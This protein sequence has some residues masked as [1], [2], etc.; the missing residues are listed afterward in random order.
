M[1]F[2]KLPEKS[3]V[4][5]LQTQLQTVLPDCCINP[6][7]IFGSETKDALSKFQEA[8]SIPVTGEA[9]LDTWECLQTVYQEELVK[10]S[11][12]EPLQIVLQPN[13]VLK[14]EED[15]LHC[16]LI[17]AILLALSELYLE[18]PKVRMTGKNDAQ[19]QNAIMWLQKKS[20]LAQTG[21]L[22]KITWR[23]LSHQYRCAV[24][25]GTGGYPYRTTQR[26]ISSPERTSLPPE[27]AQ[28]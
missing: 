14:K 18:L 26:K 6:D 25:D 21:E 11:E 17:Q 23:H 20:G 3:P 7:G 9:D 27:E 22:D 24:G 2:V 5:D 28:S 12:A 4:F 19:T 1:S 13:Q 8:H 15:N 16:Y 10:Q